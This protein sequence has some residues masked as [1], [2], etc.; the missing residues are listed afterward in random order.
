MISSTC[1][2][3]V[4]SRALLNAAANGDL[5]VVELSVKLA[6]MRISLAIARKNYREGLSLATGKFI[7][8][9]Y[10]SA[11]FF[12]GCA[13]N[14]SI[15]IAEPDGTVVKV[16]GDIGLATVGDLGDTGGGLLSFQNRRTEAAQL[17]TLQDGSQIKVGDIEITGLTVNRTSPTATMARGI[18]S[19]TR[20]IKQLLWGKWLFDWQSSKDLAQEATSQLGI[21]EGATTERAA[22]DATTEAER[23]AAGVRET[24]ILE[25]GR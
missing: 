7:A 2:V 24:E 19:Q 5:P 22:I 13:N 1:L 8:W 4:L 21:T 18:T 17:S 14:P 10:I 15:E 6:L 16:R 12:I 11:Q 3:P 9:T 23:I 25:L 20:Q